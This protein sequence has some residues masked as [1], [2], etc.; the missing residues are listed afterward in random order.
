MHYTVYLTVSAIADISV[1]KDYYNSKSNNLGNRMV[2]EVD[3]MLAHIAANPA[4]YSKKYRK[5]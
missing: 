3:I 2:S 1:A 5:C 4:T